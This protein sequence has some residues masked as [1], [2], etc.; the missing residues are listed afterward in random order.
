MF[1]MGHKKRERDDTGESS[2]FLSP[3]T[4]KI[5]RIDTTDN[6]TLCSFLE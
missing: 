4:S 3:D 6:N 5:A 2:S 1:Q